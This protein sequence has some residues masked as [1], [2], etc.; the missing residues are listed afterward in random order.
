MMQNPQAMAQLQQMN[1]ARSK[2]FNVLCLVTPYGCHAYVILVLHSIIYGIGLLR[3]N[4]RKL[5]RDISVEAPT[6]AV[7]PRMGS[8]GLG[9]LGR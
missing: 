8:G 7:C 1:H 6:A 2:P 9:G 3:R 4:R 5:Q